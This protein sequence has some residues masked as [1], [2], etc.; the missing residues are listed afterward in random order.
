M[1]RREGGR[2]RSRDVIK[3]EKKRTTFDNNGE[4]LK[5]SR[6]AIP[7]DNITGSSSLHFT[8]STKNNNNLF[9]GNFMRTDGLRKYEYHTHV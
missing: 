2:D 3:R 4:T 5:L 7:W 9:F 6:D 8:K 1:T